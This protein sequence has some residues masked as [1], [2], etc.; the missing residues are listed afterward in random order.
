MCEK[1]IEVAGF[2]RFHGYNATALSACRRARKGCFIMGA[3]ARSSPPAGKCR[4]HEIGRRAANNSSA[5]LE[6]T[7]VNAVKFVRRSIDFTA[8]LA[9]LDPRDKA[10]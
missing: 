7:F 1:L 2:P 8:F 5:C 10:R 3:T 6:T 4:G 9:F